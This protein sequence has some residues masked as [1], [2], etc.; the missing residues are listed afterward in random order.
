MNAAAKMYSIGFE[1]NKVASL[2]DCSNQMRDAGV[3]QRLHSSD[4]ND[5]RAGGNN[6][7]DPFVGN[8]MAGIG[9]QNLCG[10]HKLDGAGTL[11]YTRL[12]RQP[13]PRDVRS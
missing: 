1:K 9:M 8:W 2:R 3:E 12:P 6:L 7:A 5:R 13:S 10:G 11:G 4:P